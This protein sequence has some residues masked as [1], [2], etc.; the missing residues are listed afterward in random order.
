MATPVTTASEIVLLSGH[1]LRRLLNPGVAIAA[2]REAYTALAD[3]RSGSG[4]IGWLHDPRRIHSRQIRIIAGLASRLR[5]KSERQPARQLEL[6]QV[7]DHSGCGRGLGCKGR[8]TARNHGVHHPDRHPN[9]GHSGPGG[10][11][12]RQKD[13]KTAAIIGCGAQAKYQLEALRA[14][15]PLEIVRVFDIDAARAEALASACRRRAL[16]SGRRPAFVRP[17]RKRIFVSPAQR[18]N[19]PC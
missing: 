10:S 9:R 11:I 7:T 2:L 1:D 16:P 17:W 3:S 19:C 5:L 13:A 18:Q 15:F 12:W 4:A 14:V 8:P 6:T